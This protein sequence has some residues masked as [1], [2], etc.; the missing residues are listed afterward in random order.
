MGNKISNKEQG[1]KCGLI[2]VLVPFACAWVYDLPQTLS[3]PLGKIYN[4]PNSTVFLCYSFYSFPN[5]LF[6]FIGGFIVN[7]YGPIIF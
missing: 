3:I 7:S 5:L 1:P 2:Y 6:V 4:I